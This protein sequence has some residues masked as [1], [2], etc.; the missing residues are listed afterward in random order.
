MK[1]K[2]LYL[3]ASTAALITAFSSQAETR[4]TPAQEDNTTLSQIVV[5]GSR[6]TGRTVQNSAAPIDV[7]SA[8]DLSNTGAL[9][10]LEALNRLLP[11]FNL[12]ALV[13]PDLGSIVRGAQLRGL[14]PAYSLV[15]VNGKRRHTTALVNEDGFAG[16]V[17]VD[18]ALIPTAAIER[19]EVLRDGASALYGSDAIAGVINILL[20]DETSAN[21]L[22]V[23]AGTSFKGDGDSLSVRFNHSLRLNDRGHLSLAA[24]LSQQDR[25][26]RNSR[27]NPDYLIYPAIGANGNPVKLGA[28]NRL[29]AGASADPREATR[30]SQPWKNAGQHRQGTLALSANLSYDLTDQVKAYGFATYANRVAWAT[31]NFRTPNKIFVN[32]PKLLAIYPNGF[33][34][35]EH[36]DEDDLSLTLGLKGKIKDWTYDLS[37]TY[38]FDKIDVSVLNSANYSLSYPGAQ[39]RFHV[40]ERFY[41]NLTTNLDIGRKIGLYGHDFDLSL[42]VQHQYEHSKLSAGEP[43]SYFGSG[44]SSL[45]GY[46]P[47]DAT[48][49]NR[50]AYAAYAGLSTLITPK[51]FLDGAVRYEHYSDFGEATTG[52]LT[53]RYELTPNVAL[54]ATVSNGFHAPSLVTN[55]YSNTSDHN[56]TSYRLAQPDSN[57]ARAL[58]AKAL[59]PETS[60]NLSFG[61]S[62]NLPGGIRLGLDAYQIEVRHLIGPSSDIGI[63]RSSGVA[64]DGSG[65]PLTPAQVQII[66]TLLQSAGFAPGTSLV[67]HYFT[68]VGDLR[69]RGLDLTADGSWRT[70]LGRFRGSFAANFSKTELTRRSGIPAALANLPNIET[71]STSSAYDLTRR[72]PNDKQVLGLGFD[73]D[74]LSLDL[75]V[76]RFGALTRYST[77]T[78]QSYR[79]DP[80]FITDLNLRYR[81]HSRV[82]V[83]AFANNLFDQKPQ[84]LPDQVRSLSNRAQFVQAWDN[85]G[86]VGL[87][88]GTYGLRLDLSF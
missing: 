9:N 73:Q 53:T 47:V 37:T 32:N 75:R 64:V 36:T 34:P 40:G 33:S 42:G 81:I 62:G 35:F 23:Q 6:T 10:A 63:D 77:L 56:G 11:S 60:T 69:T 29:P 8:K 46:Q 79:L 44:S 2:I 68:D 85:S 31:Q 28:Y 7:I 3:F 30:D 1:H 67:A 84:T 58:G 71:L 20:K 74:R 88:G 39:T 78:N 54:R 43:N 12:P 22:S 48:D 49:K 52:R 55:A 59:R 17:A 83:T 45:T 70:D 16:S 65:N 38:G 18:L 19:I 51:W 13:Q 66:D 24:D 27:L 14:D 61:I 87:I 15:L 4:D 82:R 50:N 57:A 25:A 86:P 21:G 80:T 41:S 26:V 72:A 5:T 76:T